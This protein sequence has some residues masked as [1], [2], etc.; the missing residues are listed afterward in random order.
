M[1]F[2]RFPNKFA[3]LLTNC[4][5]NHTDHKVNK[6]NATDTCLFYMISYKYNIA[7][8]F[9]VKLEIFIHSF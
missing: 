4:G 9:L 6:N 7:S 5:D 1:K 3:L 2:D 8:A